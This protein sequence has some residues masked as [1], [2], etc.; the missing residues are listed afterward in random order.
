[1]N[2]IKLDCDQKSIFWVDIDGVLYDFIGQCEVIIGDEQKIAPGSYSLEEMFGKDTEE[3]EKMFRENE[4]E[5]YGD[6]EPI[7]WAKECLQ[8]IH[9]YG[10]EIMYV[11]NR[12]ESA[13]SIT[14]DWLMYFD[15]PPG[16]LQLLGPGADRALYIRQYN[17]YS[18]NRLS[19][20]P[21]ATHWANQKM[22]VF[23]DKFATLENIWRW[24]SSMLGEA[25]VD[26]PAIPLFCH[27]QPWNSG[28]ALT[29]E[30]QKLID[31]GE[32]VYFDWS[33]MLKKIMET[34][35]FS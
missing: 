3:I 10:H 13:Y 26:F 8:K 27:T 19:L 6:G 2:D 12:A 32:I 17:P 14:Q 20:G 5:L 28:D 11:T 33:V 18:R 4:S 31:L 35:S 15:F 16:W 1:M 25:F 7:P 24:K 9:E 30:Q 23:E 21:G 34:G 29:T 22:V